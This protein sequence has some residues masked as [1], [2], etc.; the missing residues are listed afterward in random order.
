MGS[1]L[2]TIKIIKSLVIILSFLLC[3]FF[4]RI[5]ENIFNISTDKII[6]ASLGYPFTII[7]IVLTLYILYKYNI[8]MTIFELGLREGFIKGLLFGLIA[9]LPMLVSSIL[10]F[11]LSNNIFSYTTLIMV[12]IGPFMEELLFRGFLF[13]QLFNKEDWGFI[14]S[15][16][17]GAIFFGIG[18]LYQGSTTASFIG[19]FLV[20]FS[21]GLW[22]SWLYAEH[23]NNLWVPVFLHI[24]MNMSWTIFETSSSGAIGTSLT[25]IFRVVTIVI[26]VVYTIRHSRKY[27]FKIHRGNLFVNKKYA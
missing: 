3:L 12:I 14:P 22:Y 7:I 15:A 2:K 21:G 4:P 24:F 9:A 27:G 25:N 1:V 16:L 10:L 17:I 5:L 23:N 26:T 19:V 20:T 6:L 13:G 18:H 11:T 8:L